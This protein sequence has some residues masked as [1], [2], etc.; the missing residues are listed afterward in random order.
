[1][2]KLKSEIQSYVE[3]GLGLRTALLAEI[4]LKR[5]TRAN[6]DDEIT[7]LFEQLARLPGS[8]KPTDELKP[9]CIERGRFN[10][11]EIY[12]AF[13]LLSRLVVKGCLMHLRK[14]RVI[15]TLGDG[16]YECLLLGPSAV[17][18]SAIEGKQAPQIRVETPEKPTHDRM[19][20]RKPSIRPQVLNFHKVVPGKNDETGTLGFVCTECELWKRHAAQFS[21]FKCDE[22]E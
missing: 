1:M 3:Q 19:V 18:L 15:R 14:K 11:A 22:A 9:W 17:M 6:I 20:P 2:S 8:A 16:K 10:V 12:D 7:E 4:A 13:P 21:D 5:R